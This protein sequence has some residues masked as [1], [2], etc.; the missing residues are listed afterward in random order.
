MMNWFHSCL[1]GEPPARIYRSDIRRG[2]LEREAFD[3]STYSIDVLTPWTK[4]EW[5]E[6]ENQKRLQAA[7]KGNTLGLTAD[8]IGSPGPPWALKPAF[9]EWLHGRL[10]RHISAKDAELFLESEANDEG[11]EAYSP[12]FVEFRNRMGRNPVKQARMEMNP[13]SGLEILLWFNDRDRFCEVSGEL[14]PGGGI[15]SITNPVGWPSCWM[16]KC[17]HPQISM[18][19]FVRALPR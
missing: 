11:L 5:E 15:R 13:Y 8:A 2:L 6:P 16:T 19:R 4:T 9:K 12:V 7:L 14:A 3:G 17:L 18:S 10:T 1:A